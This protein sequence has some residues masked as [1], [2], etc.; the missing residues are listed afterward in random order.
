LPRKHVQYLYIYTDPI[1]KGSADSEV[2]WNDY[3]K[4]WWMFYTARRSVCKDCPLPAVAIGVAS[5][6]DWIDWKYEGCNKLDA[7]G[8]DPD[9]PDILWAPGII[10]DGNI[11][12]MFLTFKKG[13]GDDSRWGISESLLLHLTAPVNDL[14]N[15][16]KTKGIMHVPFNSIDAT[17]AKNGDEWNLFHRDIM[18]GEKGINTFRITS[19]D[20][21]EKPENWNYK[22]AAKGDVNN[23]IMSGYNY[24]EGQFVFYWKDTFWMLTDPSNKDIPVYSS[25]DLESWKLNTIILNKEGTSEFQKNRAKH[26]GVAVIDDRAFVFYFN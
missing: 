20:I 23:I 11:Y 15:G 22:G 24:Q 18:K 21:N 4:E 5:S 12:H 9:G 8:G 25:K 2:V 16:W 6:K 14:L 26:P 7:I 1:Y 3:K 10:R 19:T 13:S 17:L